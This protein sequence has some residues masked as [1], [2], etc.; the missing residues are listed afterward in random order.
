[1]ENRFLGYKGQYL[2]ARHANPGIRLRVSAL[3]RCPR[4]CDKLGHFLGGPDRPRRS[5]AAFADS[6]G[7]GKNHGAGG[8]ACLRQQVCLLAQQPPNL[9]QE[10]AFIPAQRVVQAQDVLHQ[11][12]QRLHHR[13]ATSPRAAAPPP[14]VRVARGRVTAGRVWPPRS[15]PGQGPSKRPW[16]GSPALLAAEAASQESWRRGREETQGRLAA[17][18]R[19]LTPRSAEESDPVA[20][21]SDFRAA[22]SAG[23]CLKGKP[24]ILGGLRVRRPLPRYHA[25]FQVF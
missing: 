13:P 3:H 5:A 15:R 25:V 4:G 24:R 14:E 20:A 2:A 21:C 9:L 18:T 1:M 11:Y 7:L 6:E 17:E 22:P 23:R 10:R 8:R 16:A 19:D 12:R